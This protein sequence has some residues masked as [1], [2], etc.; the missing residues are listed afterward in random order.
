[1]NSASPQIAQPATPVKFLLVNMTASYPPQSTSVRRMK[2]SI[3]GSQMGSQAAQAWIN[4]IACVALQERKPAIPRIL[5]CVA[6][7]YRYSDHRRG[8]HLPLPP[9]A[10]CYEFEPQGTTL[11]G[12]KLSK[13][14]PADRGRPKVF[15]CAAPDVAPA[16]RITA[17]SKRACCR[18][19]RQALVF[20]K[21][22]DI[23][24]ACT[25][26]CTLSFLKMCVR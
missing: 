18:C 6:T 11:A 16:H 15:S 26:L 10:P 8:E 19:K 3:V 5:A 14:W 23:C 12:P 4:S 17:A 24:R 21:S 13:R 7:R 2:R 1:M 22:R 20:K 9:G 25:R